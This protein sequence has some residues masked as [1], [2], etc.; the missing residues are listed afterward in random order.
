M[1]TA[2]DL[3]A[4]GRDPRFGAG[5][6]N[7]YRAITGL[8]PNAPPVPK[9]D[10]AYAG[11]EGVAVAFHG[12]DSFDPNGKAIRYLWSFGDGATSTAANPTHV[13]VD[14][15]AGG[16]AYDVTLTVTDASNR[17]ASVV[18]PATI[19]NALP[20]VTVSPLGTVASGSLVNVAGSF[21]D[22][23]SADAPWSWTAT[24][25]GT[26]DAG[27]TSSQGAIAATVRV[28]S[29]GAQGVVLAVTDKDGGR[30]SARADVTVAA[31]AMSVGMPQ[32]FNLKSNGTF[33][34]RIY[35]SASLD[36][37]SI[38]IARLEVAGAGV[39][40]KNN[41]SFQASF[42]NANGDAYPDLVVHISREDMSGVLA[43]G[44]N[45][46]TVSASLADGCTSYA[47]SQSVVVR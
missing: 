39:V 22:L 3:G 46:L 31:N 14:N 6:I 29:T 35:G 2:D 18:V 16:A 44:S 5:R 45:A 38:D 23:G 10:A 12:G 43:I 9:T 27:V 24:A 30:G 8:E 17:S 34:V 4:P 21:S 28:C 13:Y 25:T 19:A 7:I 1:Q 33:P 37:A 36:V 41:G 20:V 40:V 42:E 32:S 15:R 11:S 47:G 26:G